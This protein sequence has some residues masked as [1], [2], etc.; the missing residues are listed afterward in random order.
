[1]YIYSYNTTNPSLKIPLPLTF[2]ITAQQN[3]VKTVVL[4]KEST[5]ANV[6]LPIPELSVREKKDWE[7]EY[8]QHQ[9]HKQF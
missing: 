9:A 3:H 2:K 1:M 5:F 7:L 6:H 8:T 4:A